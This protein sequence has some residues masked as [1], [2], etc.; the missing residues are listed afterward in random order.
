MQVSEYV[1]SA[2]DEMISYATSSLS[3]NSGDPKSPMIAACTLY[4]TNWM[5]HHTKELNGKIAE[6]QSQVNAMKFAILKGL[7]NQ[8]MISE[9]QATYAKVQADVEAITTAW[10]TTKTNLEA[11]IDAFKFTVNQLVIDMQECIKITV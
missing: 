3:P 4:P 6:V 11:E 7:V 10:P 8:P 2:T 5:S 1:L 9:A